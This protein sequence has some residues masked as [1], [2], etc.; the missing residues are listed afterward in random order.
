MH[1]TCPKCRG[2]MKP[3][4]PFFGAFTVKALNNM[5]K[6]PLYP[7]RT[8]LQCHTHFEVIDGELVEMEE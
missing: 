3:E 8:C 5:G 6:D 1:D 2:V 4:H 7:V